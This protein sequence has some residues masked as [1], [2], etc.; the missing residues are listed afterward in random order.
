MIRKFLFLYFL[1]FPFVSFSA[2]SS[3][4]FKI[5]TL[6][7]IPE[8]QFKGEF[9]FHLISTK[10]LIWEIK[11]PLC[12]IETSS[13]LIYLQKIGYLPKEFN[14]S[15]KGKAI[16]KEIFLK[17]EN[18][19]YLLNI[20]ES[21]FPS[22][23]GLYPIAI[24]DIQIN[25]IGNNI[26]W[27]IGILNL[28]PSLFTNLTG[29][30][31]KTNINVNCEK[32][33]LD[34]ASISKAFF[35]FNPQYKKKILDE[36]NF[37]KDL[38][39]KGEILLTNLSINLIEEENKFLLNT[40][41]ANIKTIKPLNIFLLPNLPKALP[42]NFVIS[43]PEMTFLWQNKIASIKSNNIGITASNFIYT[44]ND[45]FINLN[46]GIVFQGIQT[47][48]SKN[49]YFAKFNFKAKPINIAWRKKIFNVEKL[50]GYISYSPEKIEI[51]NLESNIVVPPKGFIKLKTN[52]DWPLSFKPAQIDLLV[53]NI[54][55]SSIFV[56][57]IDLKKLPDKELIAHYNLGITNLLINGNSRLDQRENKIIVISPL[58]KLKEKKK[59]TV[60]SKVESK[61]KPFDFSWSKK[62]SKISPQWHLEFDQIVYEDYPPIESL[63]ID[64][65]FDSN[66]QLA[67]NT[68][69]CNVNLSLGCEFTDNFLNC[70]SEAKVSSVNLEHLLGCFIHEAP[71]YVT[72]KTG[73]QLTISAQGKTD[74]EFIDNAKIDGL[75]NIE[76]G[77][78][79]K[80]SNL[81]KSLG[82]ILDIM[83]II[84]LNPAKL[85]DTLPFDNVIC[86][87]KGTPKIINFK[88]IRFISPLMRFFAEGNFNVDKK[89]FSLK[90]KVEK[91]IFKKNF[92]IQKNL[93]E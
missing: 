26:N 36:L 18:N 71:I 27:K 82:F 16:L 25:T 24:K 40:S 89:I 30:Y 1:I 49:K 5:K 87:I 19:N 67:L 65:M 52:F 72:G 92:F 51:S 37:Y 93:K 60:S 17:A 21:I 77:Q 4:E 58:V 88:N 10:P 41:K 53:K 46:G 83:R 2:V 55:F 29:N 73:F 28:G 90:G 22:L 80:L 42:S 45:E 84:K 8:L 35:N 54:D 68:R 32:I 3:K 85:E 59:K 78:I 50:N 14:L 56:K 15:V 81:H 91:G 69:C 12:E 11:S 20:K 66:N 31:I 79:M 38:G 74:K 39:L 34:L 7:N 6:L 76:A 47:N 9:N 57:E 13:L 63:K 70:F 86:V 23:Y 43:I 44:L 75:L 61:P 62:V 64:A 33:I 48:F